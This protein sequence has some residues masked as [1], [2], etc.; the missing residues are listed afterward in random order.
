M[1]NFTR[2]YAAVTTMPRIVNSQ[3]TETW[4]CLEYLNMRSNR[5][6]AER[7]KGIVVIL[8]DEIKDNNEF[9]IFF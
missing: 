4:M 1:S 8:Y 2:H 6:K 7:Q 9:I 3:C 5:L